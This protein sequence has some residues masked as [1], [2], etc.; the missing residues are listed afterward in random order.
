MTHFSLKYQSK[1]EQEF[2]T[3]KTGYLFR[4]YAV[5][6]VICLLF[7]GIQSIIDGLFVGNTI[8]ANALAGV[9]IVMPLYT[10]ITSLIVVVGIGCQ[11]II[12]ISSGEGNY[13]KASDAVRTALLF[14][15][16]FTTFV[17]I[18]LFCFS[19]NIIM[20]LGADE[21]LYHYSANYLISLSP[22]FPLL[23][24]LFFGD[25][26]LKS[27]G[28]PYL[29]VII[30]GASVVINIILDYI[31]IVRLELGTTGAALATGISFSI[32]AMIIIPRLF[33]RSS[34]VCVQKGKFRFRLLGNMLYNGS[35]E[36]IS[37]LSAGIVM[38]LF[39]IAMMHYVGA[40]GVAAFTSIS[41]MLYIG[42]TVFVGMSDGI[43]PVMSYNYG[44]SN[45]KRVLSI[46]KTN[47][48]V[49]GFIGITL[50]ALAF[51]GGETLVTLFFDKSAENMATIEMA[52]IGSKICAFAFLFNGFNISMSSFF[53]SMGDARLSVI[54]SILRG[55]IF[56]VLG[57]LVYPFLLEVNGVWISIPSAEFLTFFVA[58]LI[59]KRKIS[60]LKNSSSISE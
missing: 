31:L 39:N 6:G 50:C 46:L 30:L 40:A 55:L 18:I 48:I 16:L 21:Q 57:L 8:G 27:Q 15:V 19:Q 42:I 47:I 44:A 32:G 14:L 11:T 24:I 54:I 41:Y 37:E 29:S 36:G 22:F 5:P 38:F 2:A 28:K 60:R 45:M 56:V 20:M 10:F 43:I 52:I 51:F 34:P 58:T 7:I 25:F 53:T 59:L 35:S 23:S 12:C 49:N 17:T 4:K 1:E 3:A 9:N 13:Q 26:F 33:N